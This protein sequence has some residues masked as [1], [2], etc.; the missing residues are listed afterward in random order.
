MSSCGISRNGLRNLPETGFKDF[1]SFCR[2][3]G[4]ERPANGI[5]QLINFSLLMVFIGL[6]GANLHSVNKKKVKLS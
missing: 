3:N 4:T 5:I 6:Y 1:S 2:H